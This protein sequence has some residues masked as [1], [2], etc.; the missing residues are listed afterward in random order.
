ME[1]PVF[2]LT[3]TLRATNRT[4]KASTVYKTNPRNLEL[5]NKP[6]L[7]AALL[8]EH[9]KHNWTKQVTK[10]GT[11]V[12]V[13][14]T[15]T[16]V[17]TGEVFSSDLTSWDSWGQPVCLSPDLVFRFSASETALES[18]RAKKGK[19]VLE[20]CERKTYKTQKVKIIKTW[21]CDFPENWGCGQSMYLKLI[22]FEAFSGLGTC[23]LWKFSK[24]WV[25]TRLGVT[26]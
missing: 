15:T 16:P 7:V 24:F 18:S 10:L 13:C 9:T 26:S 8:V 6:A 25:Y 4:E 22:G 23:F 20:S 5:H 2:T 19:H 1:A 3:Y 21:V 14:C 12:G 11:F 17:W